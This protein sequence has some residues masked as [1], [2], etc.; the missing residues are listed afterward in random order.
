MRK[1]TE[2]N[3]HNGYAPVLNPS[4]IQSGDK[5]ATAFRMRLTKNKTSAIAKINSTAGLGL[6][7][8]RTNH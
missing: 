3:Q 8:D 6:L 4:A 2:L 5:S 7:I 1:I